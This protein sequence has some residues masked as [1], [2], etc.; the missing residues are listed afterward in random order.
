MYRS[1][2]CRPVVNKARPFERLIRLAV[3]GG[4]AAVYAAALALIFQTLENR[5]NEV[6]AVAAPVHL[7]FVQ[8][9]LQAEPAPPPEPEPLPEPEP[10]ILPEP[11]EADVA[12][13]KVPEKPKPEPKP[14]P[15]PQEPEPEAPVAKVSQEAAAPVIAVS[16]ASV[17]GWVVEQ[18]EKQKYYPPA[19]ERFGLRG[20]FELSVQVDESG[21]IV[22]AEVLGGEGHRI[23]RDA[24]GRMLAALPGQHYG[25]PI[26]EPMQFDVTFEFE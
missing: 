20:T 7:S 25:E 26:G 6:P 17:Q 1:P 24:L 13:E 22:S 14:E 4:C 12:L 21:T 18:I 2:L 8:M 15:P 16:P 9:E 23:L 19:A 3:L 11:E 5:R 10:E